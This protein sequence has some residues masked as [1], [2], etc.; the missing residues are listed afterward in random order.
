MER[1]ATASMVRACRDKGRARGFPRRSNPRHRRRL[2]REPT[3]GVQPRAAT[4]RR[5]TGRSR[6]TT[7]HRDFPRRS[8]LVPPAG[9]RRPR[10][11]GR[12][13]RKRALHLPSERIFLASIASFRSE[14]CGAAWAEV[15]VGIHRTNRTRIEAFSIVHKWEGYGSCHGNTG[16]SSPLRAAHPPQLTA[17][18][19]RMI[20]I[21]SRRP[22]AAL[23]VHSRRLHN[24]GGPP[25]SVLRTCRARVARES[26]RIGLLRR[27][28]TGKLA[29]RVP[30][31]DTQPKG[32]RG[33]SHPGGLPL[34][35]DNQADRSDDEI[36]VQ[37]IH[38]QG[39]IEWRLVDMAVDRRVAAVK[40]EHDVMPSR[41]QSHR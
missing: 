7:G 17:A 12:S 20:R 27:S 2:A 5:L 33:A 9:H 37:R 30:R 11:A 14:I 35:L 16:R 40:V 29:R 1:N 36:A 8:S 15:E 41:L 3:A 18:M 26:S 21:V 10:R 19:R 31:A 6:D 32:G 25:S 28:V 4:P 34:L 22:I 38:R 23:G 13:L 39:V 24:V